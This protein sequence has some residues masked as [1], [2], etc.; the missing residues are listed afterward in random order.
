MVN[1]RIVPPLVRFLVTLLAVILLAASCSNGDDS[2]DQAT[3]STDTTA[4]DDDET[5]ETTDTASTSDDDDSTSTSD[6]DSDGGGDGDGG[7]GNGNN[8]GGVGDGDLPGE[9]WDGFASAGDELAVMGVA[10]DDELNVREL[11][12]ASSEILTAVGPT[13][14]GL[15]ATGRARILPESLWYEVD[16]DGTVGWVSTAFVGF[17]GGTDDATAEYLDEGSQ[18]G[19]ETMVDLA[20]A[21]SAVFASEEPESRIVQSVAPTVGDLGEITYDVIGLGD[22]S[23]A[24]YRLHIFATEDNNGETFTLRTIERTVFCHRGT[25]GELCL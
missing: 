19:A 13:E 12:D 3:S 11:P 18:G 17:M 4:P 10:H 7:N 14:T 23:V 15:V 21:V 20:R 8:G 25:D 6:D 9:E 16:V 5:T 24:G 2:A 1:N 22:D